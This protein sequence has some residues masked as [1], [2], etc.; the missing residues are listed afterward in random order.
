MVLYAPRGIDLQLITNVSLPPTHVERFPCYVTISTVYILTV[1]P[2][3][4]N[5][6]T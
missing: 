1:Q 6:I 5:E 3:K 2:S 4:Q